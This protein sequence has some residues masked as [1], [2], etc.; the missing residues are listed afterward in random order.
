MDLSRIRSL[1]FDFDGTLADTTELILRSF[2]ESFSLAGLPCPSREK[3]L[4]QVGRPLARQM[5]DFDPEHADLL[6]RLYQE[7]YDRMHDELARPFPGVKEALTE[8][9]VRGYLLG[10]VTSKRA[11]TAEQGLVYFAMRD[12]FEVVISADDTERHKPEPDPLLEAMRR[13]GVGPREVAYIG[14]SPHDLKCAHA[15]GVTA[16][17]VAWGPFD[18]EVLEREKPDLWLETP[19]DLPALFP[20]PGGLNGCCR[21]PFSKQTD[22][23]HPGGD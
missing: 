9:R 18:R 16:V 15:A 6:Y 22:A 8:L 3:L 19:E 12:L 14:D 20:G 1:L 7:T 21:L 23:P 11:R 17:A 2:E 10:V 5:A 4:A 13:L